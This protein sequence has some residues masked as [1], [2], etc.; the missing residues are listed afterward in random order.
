MRILTRLLLLA[1]AVTLLAASYGMYSGT[2]SLT[3]GHDTF[4]NFKWP[5]LHEVRQISLFGTLIWCLLFVKRDSAWVRFGLIAVILASLLI[6]LPPNS[7][8]HPVLPASWH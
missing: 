6:I 5:W 1:L 3:I 4:Y 2:R 8:K 7:I